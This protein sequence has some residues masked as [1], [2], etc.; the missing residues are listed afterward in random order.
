MGRGHRDKEDELLYF[1]LFVITTLLV[2]Y[3]DYAYDLTLLLL[4]LILAWNCSMKS[5]RGT[6]PRKLLKYFAPTLVCFSALILVKPQIYTFAVILFF[7]LICW[8]LRT[9]QED[10]LNLDVGCVSAVP[11]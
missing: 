7:I 11:A 4:A 2:G 8:E 6:I 1:A 5:G 9:N 10:S 3:H